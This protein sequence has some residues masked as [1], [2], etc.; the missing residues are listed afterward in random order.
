M[1][2]SERGREGEEGRKQV[3]L[4]KQNE[5]GESGAAGTREAV[6]SAAQPQMAFGSGSETFTRSLHY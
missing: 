5:R 4:N 2:V 1:R 6:L 3:F